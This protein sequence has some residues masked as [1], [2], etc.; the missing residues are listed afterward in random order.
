MK[1][2]RIKNLQINTCV[3]CSFCKRKNAETQLVGYPHYGKTVCNEC[4]DKLLKEENGYE[5]EL[6]LGEEQLYS[7]YK[8]F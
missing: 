3:T 4:Y 7:M 1:R 2:K 8:V 5:Q 6:S